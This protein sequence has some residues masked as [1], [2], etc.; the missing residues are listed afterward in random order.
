[1]VASVFA[2][3]AVVLAAQPVVEVSSEPEIESHGIGAVIAPAVMPRG[4]TALYALVGAPEIGGGFRQG[5]SMFEIEARLTF[6]YLLA[7][8]TLEGGV[9]MS[10]LKSGRFELAPTLALGLSADSGSRYFD[11]SNFPYVALRP[12]L[13]AVSTIMITETITGLVT[14]DLP[15]AIPLTNHSAGGQFTP[16]IGAGAEMHLGG[17]LSGLLLGQIGAD[18]IKEPLGVTQTRAAWAVK[19]GL[20][21]RLF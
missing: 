6:N 12:R 2:V 8:G 21:F 20:G 19:L 1:M 10:V 15:W 13:G 14:L 17:I 18:V 5:F 11:K 4:S 9:R 3:F 16:L 7:A